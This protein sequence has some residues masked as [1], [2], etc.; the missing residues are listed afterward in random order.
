[1]NT[2]TD[3]TTKTPS[4]LY[5]EAEQSAY[6]AITHGCDGPV[7]AFVVMSRA[8]ALARSGRCPKVAGVSHD[9][10][11][12]ALDRALEGLLVDDADSRLGY[13]HPSNGS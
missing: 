13:R 3:K 12:N 10:I 9:P 8:V 11:S 6:K 4:D 1:M 5:A 2:D 7:T